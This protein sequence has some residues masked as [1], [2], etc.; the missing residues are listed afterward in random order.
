[1]QIVNGEIPF[2]SIEGFGPQENGTDIFLPAPAS[3]V[4]AV[5][6]GFNAGYSP[7]DGDHHLGNVEIRLNA[8]F[9]GPAPTTIVRVSATLGVRDWSNEWDDKYEG[10]VRFAV[11]AE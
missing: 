5:L 10:I 1:M 3:Q 6:T 11:I 7:S 9:I 2:N 4:I 8:A